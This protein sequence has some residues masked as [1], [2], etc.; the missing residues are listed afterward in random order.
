MIS[1]LVACG[2][3][4]LQNME[5]GLLLSFSKCQNK[6]GNCGKKPQN[7]E[8]HTRQKSNRRNYNRSCGLPPVEH[9]AHDKE[10]DD[11]NCRKPNWA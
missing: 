9:K 7:V 10:A 3:R 4:P 1:I 11:A 6:G 2:Q 5:Y 8:T